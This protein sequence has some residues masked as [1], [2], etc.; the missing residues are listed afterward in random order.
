MTCLGRAY[1][2]DMGALQLIICAQKQVREE[3]VQWVIIGIH[4]LFYI[5]VVGPD[6]RIPEES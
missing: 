6:Q 3:S 2:A 1:I 4:L 5:G